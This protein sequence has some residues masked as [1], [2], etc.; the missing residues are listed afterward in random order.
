MSKTIFIMIGNSDDKLS[1]AD[2]ADFVSDVDGHLD[3]ALQPFG[4]V[5]GRWFSAPDVPWQSAC[6][7]V[8]F[9]G[10]ASGPSVDEQIAIAK[11][12]M[13]GSAG[14]YRQDSIAWAE[15]TTEFIGAE[16]TA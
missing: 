1:Q 11:T 2:W 13:S 16:V 5:H 4:R 7:C 9:N 12:R 3:Y 6:W 14:S 8:E 15:A 10:A